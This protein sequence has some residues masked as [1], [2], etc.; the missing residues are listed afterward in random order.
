MKGGKVRSPGEKVKE[1]EK[2]KREW[3]RR[4][5]SKEEKGKCTLF[6]HEHIQDSQ[7]FTKLL[8]LIV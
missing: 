4:G 5:A 8:L 2:S 6:C 1:R 7:W 3:D